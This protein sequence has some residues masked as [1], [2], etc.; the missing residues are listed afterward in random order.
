MSIEALRRHVEFLATMDP[1]R[2][3]AVALGHA[4]DYIQKEF[5]K[6][7]GVVRRQT[8]EVADERYHNVIAAFGPQTGDNLVVGAHYDAVAGSPGADDN[9]S[10]VAALI[11]LAQLL[12]EERVSRPV[13]L[14]A[15][16]LEEPPYFRSRFMGSAVHARSSAGGGGG[17]SLMICLE[18]LGTFS[19][20][21]GSQ[22][23]P[24]GPMRWFYPDQGN[25]IAVVGRLRDFPSVQRVKRLI[26]EG[27]AIPVRS[28]SAP[29]FIA[30]ID[31]S[32]HLSYWNEGFSAVM[33]T[34]TAFYRNQ[35]YHTALDLPDT[36]D[37][38]RMAEVVRGLLHAVYQL[39]R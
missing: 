15:Y 32:D 22:D 3:G 24:F 10:G 18:M 19:D 8:F 33:V 30:G 7:A 38:R 16:A 14:V 21:P 1:P 17:V 5:E 27:G 37:Y 25:F 23:Y 13:E 29:T 11:E 2:T 39:A 12:D 36:L 35:R 26:A 34:D 6:G 9:A 20:E 28:L 31:F 4:A